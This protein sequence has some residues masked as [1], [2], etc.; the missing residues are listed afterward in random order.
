MTGI[1]DLQIRPARRAAFGAAFEA[2][3]EDAHSR[4][5]AAAALSITN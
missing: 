2:I 3:A 5:I 1:D 4:L